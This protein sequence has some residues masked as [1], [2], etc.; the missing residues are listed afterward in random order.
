MQKAKKIILD[1]LELIFFLSALIYLFIL[2][3]GTENTFCILHNLGFEYCPGCGLGES[4][5]LALKLNFISSVK[6]HPL[7]ILAVVLFAHRIVAILIIKLRIY[8]HG[9]II[10]NDSGNGA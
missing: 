2:P 1:N 5:N 8:K 9:Q 7:G 10:T 4:I 6:A 3:F